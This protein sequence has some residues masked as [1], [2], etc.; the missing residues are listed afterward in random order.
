MSGSKAMVPYDDGAVSPTS[1]PGGWAA[2]SDG[3]SYSGSSAG[4]SPLQVIL[5]RSGSS[6]SACLPFLKRACT[7]EALA[8]WSRSHGH[9]Q[10]NAL[11]KCV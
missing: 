11:A 1:T 5:S 10:Q 6:R 3:D 8:T 7:S 9:A 2:M 4:G